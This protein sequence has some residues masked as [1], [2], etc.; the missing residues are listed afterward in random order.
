[1][2]KLNT[3]WYMDSLRWIAILLV[4]MV[5]FTLL[6]PYIDKSISENIKNLMYIWQYGVI[7]FFIISSYTLF[8]SID[9][10][11]ENSF[12]SFYIRRFF[13]IAPLYYVI[14]IWLFFTTNWVSYYMT[15]NEWITFSNLI[16]HIFFLNGFY[17]ETYNS[18]IWVEWTI[19]VEVMFYLILPIIYIYKKQINKI[20]ILFICI[21]IITF[22]YLKLNNIS[23]L[24]FNSIYKS[25]LIQFIPFFIWIYIY[26][27]EKN[28][29]INKIFSQNKYLLLLFTFIITI[30]LSYLKIPFIIIMTL[31]FLLLIL[32]IKNNEIKIFNNKLLQFIW[33]IS[34]SIY[35][36]HFIIINFIINNWENMFFKD[37]NIFLIFLI[38]IM[39]IVL[40]STITYYLIEE[41][42]MNIW[43]KI[44]VN[45]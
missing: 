17:K 9:L 16:L 19:F 3:F 21:S 23:W 24:L 43:K 31:F 45:K 14:L 1:M 26:I 7:L 27:Y 32:I 42:F 15:N 22:I 25:P 34:Y 44:L 39:F 20:F 10:R 36:L 35:L 29:E 11:K 30:L 5:H 8:R 13:R 6:I 37:Y 28:F 4:L 40:L 41:K 38:I 12:K 18:I 2:N 33:K